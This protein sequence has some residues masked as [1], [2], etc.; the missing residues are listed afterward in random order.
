MTTDLSEPSHLFEARLKAELDEANDLLAG[1][2]ASEQAASA[3]V[4]RVRGEH[5]LGRA[6][7]GDVLR[8]Q[9]VLARSQEEAATASARIRALDRDALR[10]RTQRWEAEKD[11]ERQIKAEVRAE[12]AAIGARIRDSLRAFQAELEEIEDQVR[13]HN[14]SSRSPFLG[15]LYGPSNYAGDYGRLTDAL[16]RLINHYR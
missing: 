14:K 6:S 13:A 3:E 5:A 12:R 2:E 1:A 11:Q 15:P 8:A 16:A 9:K 7:R 4:D 10:A